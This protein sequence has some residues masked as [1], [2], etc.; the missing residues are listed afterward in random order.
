MTWS[1]QCNNMTKYKQACGGRPVVNCLDDDGWLD[2]IKEFFLSTQLLM[3][4][5]YRSVE[6]MLKLVNNYFNKLISFN[7]K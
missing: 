7:L 2:W 5:I 4:L 3:G 6:D 1:D